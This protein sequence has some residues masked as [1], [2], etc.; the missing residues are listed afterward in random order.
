MSLNFIVKVYQTQYWDLIGENGGNRL[1]VGGADI[2]GLELWGKLYIQNL[3][4][5]ASYMYQ[6]IK[7][8]GERPTRAGRGGTI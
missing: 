1:N 3:A 2:K 6:N 4:L 7:Y 5:T 8:T